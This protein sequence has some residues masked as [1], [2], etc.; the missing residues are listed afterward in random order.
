MKTEYFSPTAKLAVL[1]NIIV[2]MRYKPAVKLTSHD[3][4]IIKQIADDVRATIAEKQSQ[5]TEALAFQVQSALK[6]KARLGYIDVG[7][8]QAVA[9]GLL[10]HWPVVRRALEMMA[11]AR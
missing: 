1:E 5:V 2:A 3:V 9:N 4:A 11:G 6:C 8:Q 7:H 10:A